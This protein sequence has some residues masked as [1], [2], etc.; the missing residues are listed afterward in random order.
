MNDPGKQPDSGNQS[1]HPGKPI[2]LLDQTAVRDL[3]SAL[4]L[5]PF[6]VLADLIE[7]RIFTS[8]EDTVDFKTASLIAQKHGYR[9]ERPPP[10]MLVL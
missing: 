10:G 5:K 2:Y 8:A 6:K 9:A 3:A 7:M 4:H 1:R